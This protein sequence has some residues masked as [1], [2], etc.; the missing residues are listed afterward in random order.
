MSVLHERRGLDGATVGVWL[1]PDGVIRFRVDHPSN[2]P[3]IE[4][5]IGN[6]VYGLLR[7]AYERH[8]LAAPVMTSLKWQSDPA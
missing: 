4:V 6:K 1:E 7:V 8:G 3:E 2:D 5:G